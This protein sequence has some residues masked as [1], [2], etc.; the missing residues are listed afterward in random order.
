M[1]LCILFFSRDELICTADSAGGANHSYSTRFWYAWQVIRNIKKKI[2]FLW[3]N[4][5]KKSF[6]ALQ[7]LK[8]YWRLTTELGNTFTNRQKINWQKIRRKS[9]FGL[10]YSEIGN[11]EV[12]CSLQLIYFMTFSYIKFKYLCISVLKTINL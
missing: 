12:D 6:F 2:S 1:V 8:H 11:S 3:R 7:F 4:H 5:D 9:T 10:D